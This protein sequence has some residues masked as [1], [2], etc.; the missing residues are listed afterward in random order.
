MI[1]VKYVR[2]VEIIINYLEK[3]IKINRKVDRKD[4]VNFRINDLINKMFN[5]IR[6]QG[7]INFNNDRVFFIKKMVI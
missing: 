3:Y 7:N 1:K 5:F 6:D 4:Q 2:N